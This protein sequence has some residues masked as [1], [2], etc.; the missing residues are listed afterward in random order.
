MNKNDPKRNRSKK[1]LVNPEYTKTYVVHHETTLLEFLKQILPQQSEKNVKRIIMNHQVAVGGV[2]TDIFRFPLYDEDEVTLAW[3]PIRNHMPRPIPILY[4]DDDLIAIDKPSG[5]LSVASD[6]EKGRTAYRLVSEY[7]SSK[8]KGARIFV[9]HRLDED[10]SGVLVFAKNIQTRLALQKNW[11]KVVKARRYFAIVEPADI[12]KEGTLENYLAQDKTQKIYV[13][14]R[15]D[16]GKLAITKFKKIAER[17]KYAL[18]DVNIFTGRKNQIRVQLGHIG[19]F[20]IGD[21]KY[22]EPSN[23]I[24]RMGLHAYELDFIHPL[25]KK[26]YQIKAP[27]PKVFKDL[28]YGEAKAEKKEPTSI[29]FSRSSFSYKR[30][31]R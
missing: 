2:P 13:T 28:I 5:L 3:K 8:H 7:I 20:V 19:H 9:V 21:D 26:D 6:K 18:L 24:G 22:G 11:S 23:P 25:T 29:H 27:M 15:K 16:I 30:R 10:T 4:E 12:Q 1:G 14:T 17:G 31:K